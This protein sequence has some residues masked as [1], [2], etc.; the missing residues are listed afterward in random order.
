MG[1]NAA[2]RGNNLETL[3]EKTNSKQLE[4]SESMLTSSNAHSLALQSCRQ[5]CLI[6]TEVEE[7]STLL[8]A[9]VEKFPG[10]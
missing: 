9:V 8:K 1:W 4:S 5:R 6:E 10:L 2:K 3:Q 7:L